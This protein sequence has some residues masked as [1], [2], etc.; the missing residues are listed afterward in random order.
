V[1]KRC[2][3]LDKSPM[4][5]HYASAER[6][7][8]SGRIAGTLLAVGIYFLLG[9]RMGFEKSQGRQE[10]IIQNRG[11]Q[12]SGYVRPSGYFLL[13]CPNLQVIE[14]RKGSPDRAIPRTFVET[15]EITVQAKTSAVSE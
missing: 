4:M 3:E 8:E 6:P 9:S 5:G 2:W 10:A 7:I 12:P 14:N 15:F 13:S 1:I 11:A